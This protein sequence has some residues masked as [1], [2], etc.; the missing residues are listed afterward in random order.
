MCE[1]ASPRRHM[2]W[3]Y[4]RPPSLASWLTAP[5]DFDSQAC[6]GVLDVRALV[7]RHAG[8]YI[9]IVLSLPDLSILNYRHTSYRYTQIYLY[10]LSHNSFIVD[11]IFIVFSSLQSNT[12]NKSDLKF[13]INLF[14]K[15]N[16]QA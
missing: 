10:T 12:L 6:G 5:A 7:P 13:T 3:M 14:N 8:S 9:L 11:F 15:G 4:A 2:C 1:A 16:L